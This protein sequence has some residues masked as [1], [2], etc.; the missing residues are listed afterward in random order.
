MKPLAT[1]ILLP[2]LALVVSLPEARSQEGAPATTAPAYD[3]GNFSSETLTGKAWAATEAKDYVAVKVY[4]DKCREMYGKQAE[5]MQAKLT[6]P[7][8]KDQVFE[9]WALNDVGTSSFLLGQALEKQGDTKGAIVAYK[10]VVEKTP[11]AQCWDP[12]GWFWKP[13]DAAG[14]RLKALEFDAMD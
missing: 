12:K 8:E 11:F 2:V 7:A 14:A 1:I 6:A 4:A 3:F 5:E 13:A 10:Y 9:Y